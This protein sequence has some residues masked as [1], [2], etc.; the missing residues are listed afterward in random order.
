MGLATRYLESFR[1]DK[2]QFDVA[3]GT[4]SGGFL[5]SDAVKFSAKRKRSDAAPVVDI[6]GV[7]VDSGTFRITVP[8]ASTSAFSA[9]A[10][11]DLVWDVQ[12]TRTGS[13]GPYTLDAGTWRIL[14]EVAV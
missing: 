2:Q 9:L 13:D 3:P 4:L 5:N 14:P 8:A 10:P 6:A 1:G 7:F 11:T 12:V